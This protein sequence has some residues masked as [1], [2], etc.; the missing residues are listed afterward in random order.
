MHS[1]LCSRRVC[2]LKSTNTGGCGLCIVS[3]HWRASA[4]VHLGWSRTLI[5][6]AAGKIYPSHCWLILHLFWCFSVSHVSARCPCL[7]TAGKRGH[8]MHF[9]SRCSLFLAGTC[10]VTQ[11]PPK[12]SA[13]CYSSSADFL[14]PFL[15]MLLGWCITYSQ[16]HTIDLSSS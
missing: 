7:S 3:L 15:Y 10:S 16:L 5:T 14:F 9:T 6:A 1:W 11:R 13:A 8:L 4:V 2:F 12:L